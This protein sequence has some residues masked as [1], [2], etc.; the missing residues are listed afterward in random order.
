VLGPRVASLWSE[1]LRGPLELAAR[2]QSGLAQSRALTLLQQLGGLL[3]SALVGVAVATALGVFLAQGP[4]FLRASS[5]PRVS[6]PRLVPGKTASLLWGL[7][8]ALFT[9]LTLSEWA[10]FA[11]ETL[12]S[13]AASLAARLALWTA[14]CLVVEV[15]F[16]RARH[17]ASLRLTRR[18]HADELRA[19]YGLPALRAARARARQADGPA[20]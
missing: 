10:S 5:G 13:H 12:A 16:A 2:G 3:A 11:P 19:A 4:A 9:L 7:G 6:F 14:L 20:S 15:G 8:L 18:E 1:L 17:F